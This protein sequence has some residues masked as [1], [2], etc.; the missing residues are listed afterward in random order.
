M[1]I[2]ACS[3]LA[4]AALVSVV[5]NSTL[6]A[7]W[8][9]QRAVGG[10]VNLPLNTPGLEVFESRKPDGNSYKVYAKFAG[11][12][13][14]FKELVTGLGLG[15]FG[16]KPPAPLLPHAWAGPEVGTLSWWNPSARTP[17]GLA[18]SRLLGP[19][20]WVSA[21]QEDGFVFVVVVVHKPEAVNGP[22]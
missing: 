11:E 9:L 13:D 17:Q 20:S 12:A 19:G 21:K 22:Y 10:N 8:R 16:A 7:R 5:C 14:A 6:Y 2:I 3:G 1:L 15:I 4:L 18:G